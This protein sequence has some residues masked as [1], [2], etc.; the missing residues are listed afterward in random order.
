LSCFTTRY[1]YLVI[2]FHLLFQN[3]VDAKTIEVCISCPVNSVATAVSIADAGDS[4]L[5]KSGTYKE[6]NIQIDKPLTLIGINY[7]ILDGEHNAEIITVTAD[8]VYIGGFQIQ[9]V[10]TSY[11][12]DRAGIKL[13]RSRG[14]V[15]E[16]NRL[17]DTFFGIFLEKSN[18]CVIRGN[19]VQGKALNQMSSGNA[20][21][22]WYCK[23]VIVEDNLVSNHRDGIYFEFVDSSHIAGN[24]SKNNLRYG[25][26]FMFSNH[27]TYDRNTFQANGAGVAVMFS[28]FIVM[29]NNTFD[30]NWGSASYGL[31]LKEIYD[32]EISN[33]IFNQNTI[34][35][36][37]ESA[38][39]LLIAKNR[40]TKNGWALNILGSCYDNVF[41]GNDF[42]GNTFDLSTNSS[43]NGN[44]YN[45]NYWSEYAGYDLDRDG[46]GDVPY[47][48]LKLFSY[49]VT[50]VDASIILLRSLFI[51]LINFAEKITPLFT[52]A[53]M[54]DE[55]PLMRPQF[56]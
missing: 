56:D 18:N 54:V 26:H 13:E 14:S 10:G 51:D 53:T 48:P 44:S 9:N 50:R 47:R 21:H 15:I 41:T 5:V 12:E 33:N 45:G 30:H 36:Y 52:P 35:I 24:T 32:G 7:P 22:L 46:I 6:G 25:L 8:S 16:N 55:K 1:S 17:T 3:R 19:Q 42:I 49:V 39:R 2:V 34:G 23:N 27:D 38:N 43:R 31:L 20:I 40:F 28:K 29:T 4:I 37:G 11:I